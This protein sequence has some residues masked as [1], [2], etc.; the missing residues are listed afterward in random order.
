M[1]A[2]APLD[3][4]PVND[5]ERSLV[6][7]QA[8]QLALPDFL[9]RLLAAPVYLLLDKQFADG[10]HWDTPAN[11]LLLTNAAGQ[12]LM[13]V[14]TAPGRTAEWPARAPQF[15]FGL[16]VESL[17]WLLGRMRPNAGIVLNPGW[18]VALEIG[19]ADVAEM[20][21]RAGNS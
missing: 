2:S 11:P 8:G 6:A 19:A 12:P 21:R 9:D 10:T 18:P 5:L 3:F 13:A 15:G 7:L 17:A 4:S 1:N 14:F 16:K 20:M